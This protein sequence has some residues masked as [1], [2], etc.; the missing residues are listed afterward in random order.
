MNKRLLTILG[1]SLLSAMFLV[2]CGVDNDDNNNNPAPP[3]NDNNVNDN[4]PDTDVNNNGIKDDMENNA[5]DTLD[6]DNNKI[7]DKNNK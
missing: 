6:R 2:G 7:F 5:D 3:T 4:V 1:G